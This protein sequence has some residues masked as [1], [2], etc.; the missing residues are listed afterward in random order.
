MA[1]RCD[2]RT[3]TGGLVAAAAWSCLAKAQAAEPGLPV[4][5][6]DFPKLDW[7]ND[8]P[9]WRGP[10]RNGHTHPSC[11]LPTKFG[12]KENVRWSVALPSRG[13]SSPIVVGDAIYLTSAYEPAATQAV[14][15]LDRATG[16]PRWAQQLSQ[17]GFPENN[18]PKNTEATPTVACDGERL[19]A[20]F[21]HH[22]GIHVT[23]LGLD[24]NEVWKQRV[25]DFNPKRY[26]YGYA[27]SPVMYRNSVIIA[28]EHDGD[29]YL[30]ALE[31]A[32][33]KELWRTPRPASISF[34]SPSI[35]KVAGRDQLMISGQQLVASYD[36]ANG[37]PLWEV[38]GTTYATCGT[39]VWSGDVALASGGYPKAETIAVKADGSG[40]VLW[41][42][43]QKCY[44]QSMIVATHDGQD[45]LYALTD[46]GVAFCWRVS[47]GKEMWKERLRGPVSASPII[48]DNKIY[49]AN[50]AGTMYVF[51]AD[52]TRF[53]LIA[54]NR[55]GEEAMACPAVSGNQLFLRV[56]AGLGKERRESL[57]CIG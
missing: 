2:R 36:P 55:V 49:W 45:Y 3:F 31:R 5:A 43:A 4:D 41:K 19:I 22:K 14:L 39:M 8:W 16:K 50:E 13:H 1:L 21:F 35:G 44:E 46:N 15:A 11:K 48:A 52:P 23:A 10:Q 34:S 37:K 24:G 12:D 17:G 33:G 57:V 54:E 38:E 27:P 47:D 29:S 32:T 7:N 28:A 9:W 26:E 30:V 42:N 18:H 40:K 53:N 20:V 51:A 25:G 56:A 6:A